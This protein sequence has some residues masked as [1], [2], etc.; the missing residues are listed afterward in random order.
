MKPLIILCLIFLISCKKTES[1]QRSCWQIVDYNGNKV[2][3]IC[4]KTEA[5]LIKC[6]NDGSCRIYTAITV[7]TECNYY[8]IGGEKFC[9][10]FSDNRISE[11][12][13]ENEARMSGKCFH[14]GLVGKADCYPCKNRFHRQKKT[15]K[16]ANTVTYSSVTNEIFCGDTLSKLFQG[17]QIIRKDD[18]DSLI[19]IQFSN[20]GINW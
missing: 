7:F 17:R 16:P 9:W 10:R 5:E 20:N 6:V 2:D 8:K 18:L 15:Y 14:G 3:V 11:N 4:D 12:I 13:T 1:E 19:V